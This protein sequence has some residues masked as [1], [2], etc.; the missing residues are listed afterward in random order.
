MPNVTTASKTLYKFITMCHIMMLCK[1]LES[2]IKVRYFS[3]ALGLTQQYCCLPLLDDMSN[4]ASALA[5]P[6][7]RKPQLQAYSFRLAAL[8]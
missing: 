2:T 5:S 1:A 6:A 4:I 8:D 7:L 3:P